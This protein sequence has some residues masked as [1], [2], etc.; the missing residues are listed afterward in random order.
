LTLVGAR[1]RPVTGP[2]APSLEHPYARE[3]LGAR[4]VAAATEGD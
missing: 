3:T 2:V 4:R 1:R